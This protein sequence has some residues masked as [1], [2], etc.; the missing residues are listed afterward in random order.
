MTIFHALQ[1]VLLAAVVALVVERL[2]ALFGRAAIDAAPIRQAVARMLRGGELDRARRLAE[3]ARP[4][5]AIEPA[6]ALLDPGLADEERL[7]AM[8]ERLVDAEAHV[9]RGL[10]ALRIA[11]RIA[12]ALGFVGAA[13]EIHW[14]FNGEHGLMRLQAGLV[15]SI[16]MS[17]AFLCIA[18]GV[19]TSSFALGSWG[20]LRKQARCLVADARRMLATV[21]EGLEGRDEAS[22]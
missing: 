7:A 16:G 12:S 22:G 3:A 19:A 18:L 10:R 21:E 2:R 14:V 5:M 8:D 15:E 13:I 20:V 11:G 6:W 17:R 4:A 1:A 9:E